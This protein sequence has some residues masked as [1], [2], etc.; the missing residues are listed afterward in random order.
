MLAVMVAVNSPGPSP[1]AARRERLRARTRDE[2]LRA[3]RALVA[4]GEPLTL[5]GVARAVD[6]TAPALYRY[7]DSHED[8]VDLLGGSLYDELVDEL[9]RAR[10]AV[11]EGD[12][13]ARLPEQLTVMAHAFRTWALAHRHEYAVL[14][15]N[16]L[17]NIG[18]PGHE[19]GCTHQAGQ[20]FGVLFMEVFVA[21]WQAGIVPP[22]DLSRVD[23]ELLRMLEAGDRGP[24][25]LPLALRYLH[26]RAWARLYGTVT[27][28]VFGHLHWAMDDTRTL[29]ESMMGD[30]ADEMGFARPDPLP[31]RP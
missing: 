2:I 13:S 18:A 27:L 25:E 12:P 30:C 5:R 14:F 21:M 11:D 7:V 8:L 24:V 15:A 29:F 3:A 10:D 17:N 26:V 19:T 6:M 22:P 28:E 1:G 16:P 23:P 31:A 4:D 20:R 9:V